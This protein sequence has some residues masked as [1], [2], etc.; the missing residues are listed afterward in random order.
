M[1]KRNYSFKLIEYNV[2]VNYSQTLYN[3]PYTNEDRHVKKI[4]K[5]Q[6]GWWK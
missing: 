5:I 4:N 3:T 6:G 2:E 1:M